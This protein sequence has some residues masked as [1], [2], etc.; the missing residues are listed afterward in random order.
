MSESS[1]P[2]Q[3]GGKKGS[4]TIPRAIVHKKILDVAE[5]EPDASIEELAE[6]VNGVSAD[7]VEQVLE[8][9]GDPVA[10][11]PTEV[12]EESPSQTTDVVTEG[13][14][15]IQEGES[16]Q[17]NEI[18]YEK[19]TDKQQETLRAIHK[20]PEATQKELAEDFDVSSSTICHRVNSIDGFEWNDRHEFVKQIFEN[21]K[22]PK[23]TK[24]SA[25]Q[26]SPDLAHE[27]DELHQRIQGIEQ[28]L[29][30][31]S[32]SQTAFDDPDLVHKV[33]HACMHSDQ[34]SEEEEL[35]ILKGLVGSKRNTE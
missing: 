18:D 28:N 7:L 21:K 23:E 27:I 4:S 11:S 1:Q 8:E 22:S 10:D 19:I 13:N 3:T 32:R 33:V 29:E 15:S 26:P 17:E 20:N 16:D 34:I 35:R 30:K 9:Y 6:L 2:S 14:P 31:E 25:N 5:D 12:E 24:M